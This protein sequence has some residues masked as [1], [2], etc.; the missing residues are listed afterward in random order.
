MTNFEKWKNKF[1]KQNL[2]EFN[3][4]E[5]ALLWLKVR[6]I[7]R[8]KYIKKFLTENNIAL[9]SKKTK[10][11][12]VELFEKLESMP[13]A[14]SLLDN[15]LKDRNNEWYNTMNVNEDEL[16][17]D[18]LK[19]HHYNWGGDQNNSLD[20]HLVSRYVK[21]ISKYDDL[22]N[23]QNDIAT[24][25]W[26]Y[27]QTSW[28]NNWTSFLIESLFKRHIKVV[29]AVGEIK[30]V[31]FFL[32]NIPIDLKVTYFP[33]EYLQMKLKEKLGCKE[34][35]WLKKKA[36]D[37]KIRIPTN[38]TDS[39]LLYSLSE[40]LI[41]AGSKNVLD[42]LSAKRKEV[43]DEACD[44]PLELM[45]WLYEEQG[46]MRF[47]AEN[48]LFVILVDSNDISQSWKMKRDFQMIESKVNNYLNSF[49]KNTLSEI[50]FSY[51]NKYYRS[52]SDV[53]F[54]IK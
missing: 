54:V 5:N 13:N 11:I 39:Q 51:K 1:E 37:A 52:L 48:R 50:E 10:D 53:I 40:L 41:N 36:K 19:V 25:A 32:D 3:D 22:C 2:Y 27:V 23:K 47:G 14:M 43:I 8:E 44:K 45:T 26:N 7:C 15:F 29:S 28:Y 35:S 16:K 38:Q 20:K 17:F 9:L 46:E 6:A 42:E 34:L 4:N 21:V 30:S 24:N 12:N 33:K 18:L 49:N 31:D